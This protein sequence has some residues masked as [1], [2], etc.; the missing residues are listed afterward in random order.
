MPRRCLAVVLNPRGGKRRGV[1]VLKRISPFFAKAGIELNVHMTERP[2]HAHEIARNLDQNSVQ[3]VCVVGG[4]GT[5]HEVVDGLMHRNEPISIPLGIIPAGTGNS[6]AQ[7]LNC[8]DPMQAA[9]QIVAGRTMPLDVVRVSMG[10]QTAFCTNI[11]GWG[12]VSDIN[13]MA[14]KLRILGKSRYAAAALLEIL[15]AKRRR[16]KILLDGR[17]LQDSFLFFI[18]CNGKFTGADMKLTPGAEIG[19]GMIDVALV[20][21]A[22]R[23]QMLKLFTK[24]FDGS[25][26]S[27]DFIEFYQVR[28]F[29]IQTE[30]PD[31][32]NLDGEMRGTSPVA[33][34]VMPAALSIFY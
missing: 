33:G 16:A 14:E 8:K 13:I 1:P 26:V 10:D 12:A 27:L 11:V 7:H 5:F 24:V 32:M 18:A 22:S 19:D 2:G 9:L 20:R 30:T 15:R 21:N 34:E 4:D 17:M 29:E 25:H 6:L 3:G 31:R 28:S 23:W